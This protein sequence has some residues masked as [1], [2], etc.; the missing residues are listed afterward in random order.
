MADLVSQAP[1]LLDSYDAARAGALDWYVAVREAYAAR[2]AA[3]IQ[4]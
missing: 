2:R 3:E 1:L 4:R